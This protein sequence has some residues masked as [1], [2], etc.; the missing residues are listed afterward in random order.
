[1]NRAPAHPSPTARPLLRATLLIAAFFAVDKVAALV[2]TVI[3]ARVFGVSPLL[4]AFNAANNVPDLL[5]TLISGGALS[6]ALI[7][8]L[9]EYFDQHGR[10]AGWEVFSMVANLAFV[11]TAVLALLVAVF[12]LP[13]VQAQLGIA[14]GFDPSQ[15]VLVAQLMRLNLFATLIFSISGLVIGGLQANHH[16]LLP[17]LAPTLYNCGQIFGAVVLAPTKSLLAGWALPALGFGV[18]GLVYGV[19]IG[20]L[21][22]L[23]VQ[24]P[25]LW[26]YEFRWSFR[27]SLRHPGVLRVLLLLGPRL[28]GLGAFQ[29]T[30]L[31][32]DNLASRMGPGSVTA[33]TYG[34]FL[35]QVPETIIGTAM[36][37]ALLPTLAALTARRSPAETERSTQILS[38]ALR[39]VL[40]LTLPVAAAAWFYLPPL[41]QLVFEGRAFTP[42]ASKLVVFAA[43]LYFTGLLGHA[44][45]ELAARAFYARNDALTPTL[46]ALACML[47]Q[48]ALALGLTK[49]KALDFG[50]LAL[51]NSI[52]FS[53]QALAL[54]V[55]LRTR[56]QAIDARNVARGFAHT[57]LAT[58]VM[59][60]VL[61]LGVR[62]ANNLWQLAGIAVLAAA[63]YAGSLLA[64]GF[65]ELR[66]L[67][68][69][70]LGRAA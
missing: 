29:L 66:E 15:Q 59:G 56:R 67:A 49:I 43:R 1:M 57:A 21:L 39:V 14:P 70:L 52:A 47:L 19:I 27:I 24:L 31:M 22:H 13:L 30:E 12:A 6:I 11:V 33:L 65:D 28:A 35:M 26:R 53:I 44:A 9:S 46:V 51:A 64:S 10:A 54:L 16:F 45:L 60:G 32:R 48:V 42:E 4:D 61:W 55:L 17:A 5:F 20:A 40:A 7:P 25:G 23:A 18:H 62:S 3:I 69:N 38:T 58:V 2:R 68:R 8:V 37:T 34:W 41:V 50:G 63:I 36:G